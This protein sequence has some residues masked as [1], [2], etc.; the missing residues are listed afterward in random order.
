MKDQGVL[1][2]IAALVDEE[3]RLLQERASGAIADEGHRR[4]SEVEVELDQCWDYLRQR[5]AARTAGLPP[6]GARVRDPQT[7]ERYQQ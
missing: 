4:L 1:N 5:R 7:V 6:E 3:H 2:Q